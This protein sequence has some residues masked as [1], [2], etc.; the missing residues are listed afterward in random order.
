MHEWEKQT[1]YNHTDIQ[2][3]LWVAIP[4]GTFHH[5]APA[6]W[7]PVMQ[8]GSDVSMEKGAT[9]GWSDEGQVKNTMFTLESRSKL[10]RVG[11][12]ECQAHEQNHTGMY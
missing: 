2:H 1:A 11:Y 10:S 3:D 9:R 5:A 6:V 4:F 8:H 12:G 7:T